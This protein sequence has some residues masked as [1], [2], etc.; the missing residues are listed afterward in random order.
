[1]LAPLAVDPAVQRQGVGTALVQEGVRRLTDL[2]FAKL[3]VLGDPGYYR[4][5]GFAAE[6]AISPPYQLPEE[7]AGA[8][9]GLPLGEGVADLAGTLRVPEPWQD[10]AL[11][12]P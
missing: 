11:W 12:L 10:K 2:G 9:Q 8:W 7:W 1:M 5:H 3:F 6:T 4:R